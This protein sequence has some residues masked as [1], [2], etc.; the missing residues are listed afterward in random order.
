[1]ER[2][3]LMF[4]GVSGHG[5]G[6]AGM[7]IRQ[8]LPFAGFLGRFPVPVFREKFF[9]AGSLEGQG[10]Y[11]E[12]VHEVEIRAKG[13]QGMWGKSGFLF[14]FHGQLIH[15][16]GKSHGSCAGYPH[17]AQIQTEKNSALF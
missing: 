1:M 5:V 11:P 12:P 6:N 2:K 13:R 9:S 15:N 14:H 7:L 17:G 10:L 4:Q 16:T 3:L 8:L